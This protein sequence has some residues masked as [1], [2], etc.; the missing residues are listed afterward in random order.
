M[1]KCLNIFG[2]I[3]DF[4][5]KRSIHISDEDF[6]DGEGTPVP[7]DGHSTTGRF[8]RTKKVDQNMM[9]DKPA[10]RSQDKHQDAN[11]GNMDPILCH[12]LLEHWVEFFKCLD[13][14][15]Q[16]FEHSHAMAV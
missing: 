9:F 12:L 5:A 7:D 2:Q 6:I 14:D 11:H 3:K 8:V 10:Q 15:E 13:E 1:D 16:D 4:S